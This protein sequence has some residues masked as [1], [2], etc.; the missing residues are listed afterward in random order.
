MPAGMLSIRGAVAED[1][2]LLRQMIGELADYE[3]EPNAVKVTEE[4]L[5]RD[6]F[7]PQP[8]F[9]AV[10]AEWDGL[11]AAYAVFF[12][13]YSTWRGPSVFLEDLFVR[14][15]FRGRGIGRSLISHVASVAK[16]EGCVG[17][18]WDVLA[19]NERAI[20]FYRRLGAT[21]MDDW[22]YV[23]IAGDAFDRLAEG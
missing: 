20:E 4:V 16:Q 1:V 17:L 19:W 23:L 7:G 12:G 21:F 15:A 22:R 18:R 5:L 13:Y 11:P 14:E 3:H 9:R 8:R 10:I 2:P 6:G